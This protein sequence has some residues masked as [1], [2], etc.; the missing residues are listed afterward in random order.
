MKRQFGNKTVYRKA[1]ENWY[2]HL[3]R[4]ANTAVWSLLPISHV[5]RDTQLRG[6]I[7]KTVEVRTLAT[8]NDAVSIIPTAGR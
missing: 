3:E 8:I 2:I 5:F 1:C 6:H 4:M 7:L